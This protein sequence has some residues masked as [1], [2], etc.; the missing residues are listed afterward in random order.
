LARGPCRPSV[1][2]VSSACEQGCLIRVTY[3][4]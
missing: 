3:A 2:P 1:A 4:F